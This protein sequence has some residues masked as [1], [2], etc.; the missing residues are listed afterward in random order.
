[1]TDARTLNWRFVV[2]DE[3][4]GLLLLPVDDESTES[5]VLALR[6]GTGAFL[7]PADGTFPAVAAADL[8]AWTR[9]GGRR[10]SA[11]L[12]AQLCSTV[13]P[14]GWLCIGFA[15]ARYP[16]SPRWRRSLRLHAVRRVLRRSG[17]R[18]PEIYACLPDHR[19]PGLLVPL[20]RSAELDFVLRKLF[21]TYTSADSTWPG[22]RRRV[23]GLM[24]RAAVSAPHGARAA[25]VP[26]YCL[27][28]R[29]PM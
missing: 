10:E 13:S 12:L 16:G 15:N 25:L 14:G 23:L 27:V 24:H 21:L 3:P 8:T 6:E 11:R 22:L 19:R 20:Q 2:P 18:A 26:G 7:I 5:S 17:M 28:S 1:M 29:R 4:S 9:R